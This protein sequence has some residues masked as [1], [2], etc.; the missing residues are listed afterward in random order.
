VPADPSESPS[1]A[2]PTLAVSVEVVRPGHVDD[3]VQVPPFRLRVDTTFGRGIT[4]VLGA[5]G[6]G[7]STLLGVIAGL[8]ALDRGR[9]AFGGE[10]WRDTATGVDV[11]VH[12]RRVAYLFQQLALFPHLDARHN[13]AYPMAGGKPGVRVV[14]R[15]G[16]AASSRSRWFAIRNRA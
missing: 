2:S 6:S 11:P 12:R 13:V 7:K 9:V 15:V 4:C 10:V 8:V 14:R 3:R 1:A 16:N 5:S